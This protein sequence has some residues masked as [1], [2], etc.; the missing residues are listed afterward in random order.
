MDKQVIVPYDT[1][2]ENCELEKQLKIARNKIKEL[3]AKPLPKITMIRHTLDAHYGGN[4]ETIV[5]K[6]ENEAVQALNN[7]HNEEVLNLKATIESLRSRK[8]YLL[9]EL[10]KIKSFNI[11]KFWMWKYSNNTYN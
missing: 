6:T 11:F 3:E 8:R 4:W 10:S 1:Y 2:Q 9:D 5:Y 7:E